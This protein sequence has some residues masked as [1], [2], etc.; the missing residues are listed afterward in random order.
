MAVPGMLRD[1]GRRFLTKPS[2][3]RGILNNVQV[4]MTGALQGE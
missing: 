2:P 1:T 4:V 3:I